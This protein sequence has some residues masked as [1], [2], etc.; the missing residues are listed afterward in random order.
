MT[1][2]EILSTAEVAIAWSGFNWTVFLGVMTISFVLAVVFGTIAALTGK[3]IILGA[4]IF[5]LIFTIGTLLF[6]GCDG[7]NRSSGNRIRN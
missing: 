3:D 6:G 1:G 7:L 5:G 4:V 2:V